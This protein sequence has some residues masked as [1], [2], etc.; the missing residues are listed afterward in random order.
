[1]Y[2]EL[3]EKLTIQRNLGLWIKDHPAKAYHIGWP[4]RTARLYGS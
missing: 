3:L 1:L 4:A 2:S